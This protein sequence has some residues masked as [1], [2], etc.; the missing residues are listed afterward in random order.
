METIMQKYFSYPI[1]LT[2]PLL[3][4]A[5]TST[6][7]EPSN[8]DSLVNTEVSRN[9]SQIS[10][11][12]KSILNS[13]QIQSKASLENSS[14][15]SAQTNLEAIKVMNELAENAKPISEDGYWI[16]KVNDGLVHIYDQN[17]DEIGRTS[18]K[19]V[20]FFDSMGKGDKPFFQPAD[21]NLPPEY[22]DYATR[23]TEDNNVG[24]FGGVDTMA[25][26]VDPSTGKVLYKN[27]A[28]DESGNVSES[29]W[30]ET[31]PPEENMFPA[32]VYLIHST[33]EI[34]Q[35]NYDDPSTYFKS[36]YLW[37]RDTGRVDGPYSD[38]DHWMLWNDDQYQMLRLSAYHDSAV[39][40]YVGT[41]N[42]SD[43][44]VYKGKVIRQDLDH[45]ISVGMDAVF[46]NDEGKN[47]VVYAEDGEVKEVPLPSNAQISSGVQNNTIMVRQDGVWTLYRVD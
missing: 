7:T 47:F 13:S 41:E 33:D 44:V 23:Q 21:D 28:P 29:D 22:F 42:G 37:D 24:G 15:Q 32:E 14:D 16:A 5:C 36:Y 4:A 9:S 40:M 34:D 19:Q 35:Y 38:S 26:G 2:I 45:A 46:V 6:Q 8:T 31:M 11:D 17:G 3:L 10:E 27:L 1:L 12:S 39:D 18:Y 20:T 25:F 43:A 30:S